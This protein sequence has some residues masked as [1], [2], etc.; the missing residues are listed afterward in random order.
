MS[1]SPATPG[2]TPNDSAPFIRRPRAADP[3]V[4]KDNKKRPPRPP[5]NPADAQNGV[6][7]ISSNRLVVPGQSRSEPIVP[8]P[9][10]PPQS[11]HEVLDTAVSGFSSAPIAPVEDFPLFLSVKALKDEMRY[12]VARFAS[13]KTIDPSN[14]NEF[15]R[16]VR[17]HRRDARAPP[18]GAKVENVDSKEGIA[19]AKERETQEIQKAQR[20]AEREAEMAQVAPSVNSKYQRRPG[21]FKKKTQQVYRKGQNEE[22][23]AQ[24]KLRYEEALPW[25]L[26]DFDNKQTWVGSYEAAL[27]GTNAM[28]VKE[29]GVFRITPID[30]WYKFKPKQKFTLTTEEAETRMKMPVKDSRWFMDIQKATKEKQEEKA[31][32]STYSTR[33]LFTG[34]AVKDDGALDGMGVKREGPADIDALD[35]DE[36]RFA[37]DEENPLFEGEDD[38]AKEAESRIKQDQLQANIFDLKDEK[39]Y[40]KAEIREKRANEAK[41]KFGKK[42]KKALTKREKNFIYDSDSEHPYSEEVIDRCFLLRAL[43][44]TSCAERVFQQ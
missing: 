37:D 24:S 33:G 3:L 36:D 23:K 19:E 8:P 15:T 25:H 34:R 28:L 27:S 9:S 5:Q 6:Q 21:A 44:L 43:M 22:E 42:T 17:L 20:E 10:K 18:P 31:N 39:S 4:R 38:E 30:K 14:E 32:R 11:I 41:R 1:A 40:D 7:T 29:D 35:F 26:E 13:K 2:R 16:P 12:H